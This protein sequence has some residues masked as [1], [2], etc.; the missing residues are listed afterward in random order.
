MGKRYSCISEWSWIF[1][2]GVGTLYGAHLKGEDPQITTL[3]SAKP[4]FY[5][6]DD[7]KVVSHKVAGA[8]GPGTAMFYEKILIQKKVG[9]RIGPH[10]HTKNTS[11]R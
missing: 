4:F 10:H 11:E 9:V 6:L 8:F 5:F 7:N 1:S 3:H 2:E